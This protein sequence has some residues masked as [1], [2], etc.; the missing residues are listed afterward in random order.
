MT[1]FRAY[2]K[3]Y[4]P[5]CKPC[6]DL[7]VLRSTTLHQLQGDVRLGVT[8]NYSVSLR[9]LLSQYVGRAIAVNYTRKLNGP[10][11]YKLLHIHD[12][13]ITF[14]IEYF[15]SY[16]PVLST[17]A[18]RTDANAVCSTATCALLPLSPPSIYSNTG[19]PAKTA[20]GL[21][22]SSSSN[23]PDLIQGIRTDLSQILKITTL[24]AETLMDAIMNPV[25]RLSLG[26][27]LLSV[28]IEEVTLISS[29]GY[30]GAEAIRI[31][32]LSSSMRILDGTRLT[33]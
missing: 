31:A 3:L 29:M 17:G 14:S 21:I 32:H 9:E 26:N 6:V 13:D 4:I 28:A 15:K 33:I 12:M 30:C 2:I 16:E 10:S 1:G 8:G 25:I 19:K 20:T 5:I 22:L 18:W 23:Q 27:G 11:T 24:V 7:K